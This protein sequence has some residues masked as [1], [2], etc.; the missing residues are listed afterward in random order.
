MPFDRRDIEAQFDF[1]DHALII[2]TSDGQVERIELVPKTVA[3]FYSEVMGAVERLGCDVAIH[4]APNE[5]PNPIPFAEDEEHAAYNPEHAAQLWNALRHTARVMAEFRAQFI[6]KVSPIH[7]FWGAPDLAVTRFSGRLAPEHAGG[8]PNLPDSIAREAYSH[9]VSSCGFWPGGEG[10]PDPVFYAYAY[11][12]PDGFSEA[13]VKPDAAFW[14][15]GLGEF[16]LPY[17]VVQLSADPDE[18]LHEFF[19]STYEAAADL[20][21]WDR[22]NLERPRGF[23]PSAVSR[24]A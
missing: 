13:E 24:Q 23:H 7:F 20:A 18:M 5:V 1:I 14:H 19:Q 10:Y 21:S 3:K 8:V 6:G 12:T 9:E 17:E 16:V 2:S 22:A 11:P 15:K 4:N